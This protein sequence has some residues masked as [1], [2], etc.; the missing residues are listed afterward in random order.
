MPHNQPVDVSNGSLIDCESTIDIPFKPSSAPTALQARAKIKAKLNA[1]LQKE[2]E[3]EKIKSQQEKK[4]G[5]KT[6]SD[7]EKE[8]IAQNTVRRQ[9]QKITEQADEQ[10]HSDGSGSEGGSDGK[11]DF[12]ANTGTTLGSEFP[13]VV[14]CKFKMYKIGCITVIVIMIISSL[15]FWSWGTKSLSAGDSI[16]VGLFSDSNASQ[17]TITH[18]P[19]IPESQE[20]DTKEQ[21]EVSEED[22]S[23]VGT[24]SDDNRQ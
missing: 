19:T 16:D 9:L 18:T 21:S 2:D 10:A 6:I 11:S 1:E 14:C 7:I 23:E 12:T 13:N 24:I 4:R 17:G 8:E 5:V 22:Q 20:G 3:R 15:I